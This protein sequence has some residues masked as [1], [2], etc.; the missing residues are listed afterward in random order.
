MIVYRTANCQI[1]CQQI[2]SIVYRMA[3]PTKWAPAILGYNYEECEVEH[4]NVVLA[5]QSLQLHKNYHEIIA[6]IHAPLTTI[7]RDCH[8][9]ESPS[10]Y[11]NPT[12]E[13]VQFRSISFL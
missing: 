1:E 3:Q 12:R 7:G 10:K 8:S 9:S 4:I 5:S 2:L 11:G 13:T 6:Y